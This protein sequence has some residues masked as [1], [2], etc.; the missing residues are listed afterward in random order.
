MH[1][2]D[3]ER[4]NDYP[5][6]PP[7]H[8]D[9]IDFDCHVDG[10]R[11]NCNP[12]D[13]HHEHYNSR[14][15]YHYDDAYRG[16]NEF[17]HHHHHYGPP[18]G[19][20]GACEFGHGN[21]FPRPQ[22]PR[23]RKNFNSD[24]PDGGN[25]AKLFVGAVPRT[26]TEEDI[27]KLFQDHG[28]V[29]EVVLLK[30]KRTGQQNEYCFVKY[31]SMEDADRAIT[32]LH[33][34]CT[35][36][37]GVA[38]IRVKYADGERERLAVQHKVYVNGLNKQASKEEIAEIFSAYGVV[39]DVYIMFD[40]YKQSRGCGFVGFSNR[41][42]AVAAINGLNGI[43]MMRGCDRPLVVR[44]ADPKKPRNGELRPGPDCRDIH[45]SM[46]P[47]ASH[48][49][50]GMVSKP[51][52]ACKTSVEP[53]ATVISSESA[54]PAV[55]GR[56][57]VI[58]GIPDCDW[59]EHVCPDGYKYYYNCVT[60]ESRWEKPEEFAIYEQGFHKQLQN[61]TC[62]EAQPL[63][64]SEGLSEQNSQMQA[65]QHQPQ[66]FNVHRK[67]ISCAAHMMSLFSIHPPIHPL[68]GAEALS[69][70]KV[71]D[72]KTPAVGPV[73]LQEGLSAM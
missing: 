73:Q 71:Q 24:Y 57:S 10:F 42:M 46:M 19:S 51:Q 67:P 54:S 4:F 15:D 27:R 29:I 30:D 65:T 70:E 34:R 20:F 7:Q 2:L 1:R 69:H 9:D 41:D 40:E 23:K 53:N 59:S 8:Y 68:L 56:D 47:D 66:S 16:S 28:N 52:M 63:L 62:K 18:D 3:G 45:G 32:A 14:H 60:Y 58:S 43:Y 50:S 38:P 21:G 22:F 36:P 44:F 48:L 37:G 64:Q 5:S 72:D 31:S 6:E 17:Y 61:L 49:S 35:L 26:V 13:H 33:N 39:E 55:D 12:H 11:G 25:F